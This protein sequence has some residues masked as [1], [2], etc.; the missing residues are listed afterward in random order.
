MRRSILMVIFFSAIILALPLT[1][2]S[3]AEHVFKGIKGR[4]INLVT[5]KEGTSRLD[6]LFAKLS[7]TLKKAGVNSKAYKVLTA[8]IQELKKSLCI[9]GICKKVQYLVGLFFALWFVFYQL[10]FPILGDICL[11]I[12]FIF[13]VIYYLLLCPLFNRGP[14]T[15]TLST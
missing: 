4:D 6:A 1:S 15:D 9:G 13:A 5:S 12:S 11:F 7:E 14:S 3:G 8:K 10:D 2:V